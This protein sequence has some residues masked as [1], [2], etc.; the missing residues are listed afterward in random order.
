[1]KLSIITVTYDAARTIEKTMQSVL[2]QSCNDYEYL[3]VDGNS[4]DNTLAIVKSMEDRVKMGEFGIGLE[5]FR[6]ISEPD[7]GLY[8]AMNKALGFA[9]GEF[10]WFINAGDKIYSKDTLQ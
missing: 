2:N 6:W 1:M 5:Q 7:K 8:D 10:V 4:S 9:K 3:I